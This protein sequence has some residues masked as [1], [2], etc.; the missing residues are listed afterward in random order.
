[1]ERSMIRCSVCI[2]IEPIYARRHSGERLCKRCFLRSVEGKVRTTIGKYDMFEIDD[3]IAIA[4]SGG[5]D[6]VSLLHILSKIEQSFPKVS[7]CAI[8]VDEGI[9]GYRDEAIGIAARNCA[10]LGVEH[11]IVSFKELFGCTMDGVVEK[12]KGRRLTPCAYCGVLRRRALNIAAREAKA[13]KIATAHNLDDEVQTFLLNIIHGDSSRIFRS[14]SVSDL[15]EASF[16]P[17]VKPM[18]EVLEREVAF[19]AHLKHIPFQEMP[20]PYAA[21]ALRNDVRRI[22][23]RLEEKHPGTKYTTYSST[24]R[25]RKA[26]KRTAKNMSLK[27]CKTCGEPTTGMTCQ[28][29]QLLH[30]LKQ[31]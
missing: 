14:E 16:V 26:V 11:I 13:D 3:R 2:R 5:K 19:Y 18:S 17:R 20:C 15:A 30:R 25:I 29:C 21:D 22:L 12:T 10:D 9:A 1:M 23:N 7:L 8:T 24:E 28:T 6:S 27:K 4:V 31:Q